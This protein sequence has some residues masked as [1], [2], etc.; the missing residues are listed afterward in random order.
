MEQKAEGYR[1]VSQTYDSNIRI[2]HEINWINIRCTTSISYSSNTPDAPICAM[3][4][5]NKSSSSA[6]SSSLWSV[7]YTAIDCESSEAWVSMAGRMPMK[8]PKGGKKWQFTKCTPRCGFPNRQIKRDK[9]FLSWGDLCHQS[10]WL[11]LDVCYHH[12]SVCYHQ[13][14]STSAG[15]LT[16]LNGRWWIFNAQMCSYILAQYYRHSGLISTIS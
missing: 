14:V 11:K 16:L 10:L 3:V 12:R 5:W 4:S 7:S 1:G 15:R 6:A 8:L 13:A 2:T 9:K